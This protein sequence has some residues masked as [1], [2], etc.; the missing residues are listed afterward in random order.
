MYLRNFVRNSKN[1]DLVKR[2]QLLEATPAYARVRFPDGRE[3]SVSLQDLAG[4]PRDQTLPG[5]PALPPQVVKTVEPGEGFEISEQ[6][7]SGADRNGTER[8]GTEYNEA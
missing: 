5:D 8:I 3:S 6:P 4:Y 7:S 1:D 2:V